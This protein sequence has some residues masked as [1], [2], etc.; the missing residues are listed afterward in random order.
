MCADVQRLST[1]S[2]PAA[3]Q[4]RTA[5]MLMMHALH[6]RMLLHQ[7]PDTHSSSPGTHSSGPGMQ[8][9]SAF[10]PLGPCGQG[11]FAIIQI[12]VVGQTVLSQRQWAGVLVQDAGNIVL[13]ISIIAGLFLW[14]FGLF[15]CGPCCG[16]CCHMLM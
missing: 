2:I 8:V 13:A 5:S 6:A 11:A 1:H 15:W 12:A 10:I 9:I 14:A 7:I 16:L 4:V 3:E